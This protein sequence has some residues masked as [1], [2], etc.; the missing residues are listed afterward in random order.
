MKPEKKA[1]RSLCPQ[2]FGEPV[3]VISVD[4]IVRGEQKEV[5]RKGIGEKKE[6]RDE[7]SQ[8]KFQRNKTGNI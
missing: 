4:P 7:D 2:L 1:P 6:Q 3:I 8:R 5:K